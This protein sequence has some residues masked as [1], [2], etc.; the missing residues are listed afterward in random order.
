M[1]SPSFR[2][3]TSCET[4]RRRPA[5]PKRGNSSPISPLLRSGRVRRLVYLQYVDVA[6]LI[7]YVR[8]VCSSGGF[9]EENQGIYSIKEMIVD[10]DAV[11]VSV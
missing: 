4:R 1:S 5:K 3:F 6:T 9:N 2:S 7:L 8:S 11:L 10:S